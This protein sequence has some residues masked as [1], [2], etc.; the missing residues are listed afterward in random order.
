MKKSSLTR[1]DFLKAAG[2]AS[3]GLALSACGVDAASLPDPTAVP[4]L[5]PPPTSTQTP[6]FTPTPTPPTMGELA[7]KLGFDIGISLSIDHNGLQLPAYQNFIL[8]FSMLT[9]GAASNPGW[10]ES[11]DSRER[12]KTW[13]YWLALSSLCE[14]HNIS[15]D[16]NHIFWGF[17]YFQDESPIHYLLNASKAEIETYMKNRVEMMFKIPYFTSANFVNEVTPNDPSKSN[18]YGFGRLRNPFYNIYGENYP[19]ECYKVSW[20]EAEKTGRTVGRD[21][22]LIY[23]SASI[24]AKSPGTDYSLRYANDLKGKLSRDFGIER[25][26][27]VGMQFHITAIDREWMWNSAKFDR[28]SLAAHLKEVAEIGDV[29]I[30]EFSISDTNDEQEQKDILHTI[31]EGFIDSKVGKSFMM[32][33]PIGSTFNTNVDVMPNLVDTYYKPKF[34]FDELYQ[35]LQSRL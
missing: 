1:R 6:T 16:I 10:L 33:D 17:G 27:D 14:S 32:W 30:T 4:T 9:D 24:E 19:Y 7:R 8:N 23:N 2:A 21:V 11:K 34:M 5:T 13:D 15:L 26:F 35:I 12:Q 28:A 22:H 31:V 25:P 18:E 29:R 3:A 20:N